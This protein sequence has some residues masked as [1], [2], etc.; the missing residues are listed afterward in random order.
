MDECGIIHLNK[1]FG[2]LLPNRV[3]HVAWFCIVL[4]Y[5]VAFQTNF[6]HQNRHHLHVLWMTTL[7]P[8][9]DRAVV[10][11][12]L[13]IPWPEFNFARRR[14]VIICI[15]YRERGMASCLRD[16]ARMEQ[17]LRDRGYEC[18]VLSDGRRF[19]RLASL[20]KRVD[21]VKDFRWPTRANIVKALDWLMLNALPGDLMFLYFAGHGGSVK[22]MTGDEQDG[23]DETIWALDGHL[24]DDLLYTVV[25]QRVPPGA[26]LNVL[27]D[28]CHSGSALDLPFVVDTFGNLRL[29]SNYIE[30]LPGSIAMISSSADSEEA[31]ASTSLGHGLVTAAFLHVMETCDDSISYLDLLARMRPLILSI[32]IGQRLKSQT[33]SLSAALPVHFRGARFLI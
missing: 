23:C 30:A 26:H 20:V 32:P 24:T 18:L 8:N 5:A 6:T 28:S 16:G 22:D 19:N 14:A 31:Q 29:D 3:T 21:P 12:R 4:S 33:P 7:H 10:P 2:N 1:Q 15:S 27:F 13:L 17:F 11:S 25:A 9:D